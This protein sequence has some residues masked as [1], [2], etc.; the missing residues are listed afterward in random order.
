MSLA[1]NDEASRTSDNSWLLHTESRLPWLRAY[2]GN[3]RLAVQLT[4]EGGLAGDQ[5]EPLHLMAELYDRAQGA[6]VEHPVPLPSWSTLR[7]TVDSEPLNPEAASAYR[8][9][10]DL[11]RGQAQTHFRWV[12]GDTEIQVST[13]Q[14]V[15]RH[16]P[17]VALIRLTATATVDRKS[18]V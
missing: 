15:L 11:R 18:V 10:L 13:L 16:E 5:G 2:L 9:D 14:A 6:E 17:N 3:G 4:A 12:V 8:Q 7:L 1:D